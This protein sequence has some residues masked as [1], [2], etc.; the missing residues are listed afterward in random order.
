MKGG[1]SKAIS[2]V[3]LKNNTG[4][5]S[6][7]CEYV[8]YS[9]KAD[10]FVSCLYIASTKTLGLLEGVLTDKAIQALFLMK[11]FHVIFSA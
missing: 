9:L 11:V 2:V 7:I 6:V 4:F 1:K 3:G 8:E 10:V 5:M